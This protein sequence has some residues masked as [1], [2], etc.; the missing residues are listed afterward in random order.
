V[1]G[2]VIALWLAAAAVVVIVG[3]GPHGVV[4]ARD[5]ID[6]YPVGTRVTGCADPL[7]GKPGVAGFR[8]LILSQVGGSDDGLAVCKRIANNSGS[9][10]DHADGR[11]WDWHVRADRPADTAMVD[12]VLDWLLRTDERGNQNAVA[13]RIG[14]TYIIWNH[15]IYRVRSDNAR[16]VPY[17]GTSDPHDTHVHFSFSV[18]GAMQETS[19][20]SDRGPLLWLLSNEPDYPNPLGAGALHAVA[21]DWDGDGRDTVGVYNPASRRFSFRA[22]LFS[23][24]PIVTTPPIGQFGAVPLVGN[25]DGTGGDEVGVYEPWSG[26]FHFYDLAGAVMRPPQVLGSAATLPIV[27]DWNG[28]RVDEV[29]TYSPGGRTFAKVLADG[30]VQTKVFGQTDDTPVTGDWNGDGTDDIGAFRPSG[31]F[32]VLDSPVVDGVRVVVAKTYGTKRQLPVI[33]DWDGDG[34]DTEGIVTPS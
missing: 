19:W 5:D 31:N 21:G 16:W 24:D 27:G 26:Q 18:R 1:A 34:V 33:G 17:T 29:G 3:T 4:Q 15:Q 23:D 25:W 8:H 14:I 11:A 10:S 28:D 7:V 20:W 22:Q 13:R 2:V 12:R 9:F 30:T 32:F 6:P